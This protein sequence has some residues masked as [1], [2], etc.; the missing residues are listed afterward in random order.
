[1]VRYPLHPRYSRLLVAAR[2]RGCMDLV[3]AA[4]ALSESR[5]LILPLDSKQKAREREAWWEAADGVSD[6]LKG[7]LA[8]QKVMELGGGMATCREWG[9]HGQSLRQ[10]SRVYQQL[11]RLAGE[12]R[13]PVGNVAEAFG[14]CL[15]TGYVDHLARRLDRGTLRCEMVHGRRGELRRESV[16]HEAPLFVASEVEEREFRGEATLF[17]GGATAVEEAWLEEV[18]P[19]E[20][21]TGGIER[22]DLER[23]RVE[24]VERTAF[25]GLVL[26]EKV[27]GE[28]EPAH[29]A[30]LLASHIHEQGWPLKKWD[31][32][33]ENWI[34]RVNVLAAHCPEWE[35]QPIREADRL[36]FIEQLCEGATA[37]KQV[38][39]RDIMPILRT[40]LPDSILPLLDEWVPLRF[41]LPGKGQPKLRYEVDGTVVLPARIQQ[42]YDVKGADLA[43]CQGRCRL[44]IEL[45]AP[46]NRPVQITDD[47]DGFWDGQYPQIRK[48]LFGR[49]P[50]HEWR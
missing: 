31:A 49:Y 1:M 34:R 37:Y 41:P 11:K 20:L 5:Q 35:I 16:V 28:P 23:R 38:K 40:W 27:A 15:L 10:A 6:L 43:V 47:L 12:G 21:E 17:L 9:I 7:V 30:Q 42:L 46:N 19:G 29:A 45:L 13:A 32:N 14:K 8:W 48:D 2:E 24:R 3:L 25:R 33:A 39:D 36:L 50:K 4:I 18:Y 44:R 26:R 22:M